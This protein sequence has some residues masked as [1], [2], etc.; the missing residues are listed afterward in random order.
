MVARGIKGKIPKRSWNY[1]QET[2]GKPDLTHKSLADICWFSQLVR[3][4]FGTIPVWFATIF[5]LWN[6]NNAGIPRTPS[7]AAFIESESVLTLAMVTGISS[8]ICSR[9]GPNALHGPH[10]GAQKSTRTHSSPFIALSNSESV[11]DLTWPI[12]SPTL[13]NFA[14]P[15]RVCTP[16]YSCLATH[17]HDLRGY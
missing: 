16:Q 3:A 15:K 13:A 14:T 7:F 9:I 2:Q 10:H 5:P 4:G 1:F 11:T 12:I 6:R 8:A 17:S